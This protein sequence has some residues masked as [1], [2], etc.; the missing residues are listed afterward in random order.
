MA[1]SSGLLALVAAAAGGL[2]LV[3][4]GATL[5]RLPGRARVRR[6][7]L[8]ESAPV[9]P[10]PLARVRD[11]G[12]VDRWTRSRRREASRA[13][14][15]LLLERMGWSL[16][17]GAAVPEALRGALDGVPDAL[18]AELAPT[19]RAL[20]AGLG[21]DEALGRWAVPGGS[22]ERLVMVA[23]CLAASTGG[24]VAS[25]FDN[26]AAGLRE[27]SALRRE[28]RAL[29]AQARASA[30]ASVIAPALFAVA[31]AGADAEVDSFLVTEPLGH[32]CLAAG[33]ALNA[34]GAWWMHRITR[35]A[36]R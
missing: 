3:A 31:V 1:L 28:T 5:A 24:A 4:A 7:L 8:A 11:L 30:A 12:V 21:L 15:P 20:D 19:R 35:W 36:G 16:R 6:E 32:L 13:E 34:G 2:L 10:T 17:A 26:I 22:P 27:Q 25:T 29:S 23:L 18:A 9:G 14:L 33:V